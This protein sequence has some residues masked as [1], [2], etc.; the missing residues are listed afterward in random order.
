MEEQTLREKIADY[1]NKLYRKNSPSK[2]SYKNVCI[3]GG[4][5]TALSRL[6]ASLG[7]INM[8]HFIPDYTAY[9]ELLSTFKTFVPI[10]I[11]L[12][13]RDAYKIS[14]SHL[15]K[16]LLDGV[17]LLYLSVIHVIPPGNI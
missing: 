7:N 9:E 3:A 1:Y 6:V 4:G 5:R 14:L 8:G 15:E 12:K 11:L 2:Y 10:G 13:S 17:F 16:K